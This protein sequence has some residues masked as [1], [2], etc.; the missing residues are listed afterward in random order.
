MTEPQ[1]RRWKNFSIRMAWRGLHGMRRTSRR[2]V[3]NYIKEF[4][5]SLQDD[6]LKR[7][8]GWDSTSSHPTYRD[9][10]GHPTCGTFIYDRWCPT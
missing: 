7:I 5:S 10:Y 4:F 1:Y 6:L 8:Q 3:A 2:R 9:H